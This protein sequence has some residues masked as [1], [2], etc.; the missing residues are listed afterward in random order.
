MSQFYQGPSFPFNPT[1]I[2]GCKLWMD[3][4]DTSSAS[5]TLSGSTVTQWKDKSGNGNNTTAYSGTP[6]ITTNAINS[7]PAISMSGG[8]FTGPFATANTG[9]QL[10]A[11]AVISIDSSSGVWPRPLSLGRPGVVDYADPTT[12][13]AIIRYSGGQAVG[14]GRNSQYQST[15]FP[16][17]SSPFLVQSSHNGPME[18]IGVNGT[19]TPASLNDGQGGNFNITSYG[20]G[21]NTQ[22][23]DYFVWNGYYAE[24]IYFNVQLTLAQQQQVEGYLAW[25][26]GLQTQL[27]PTH[28]YYSVQV[29]YGGS[30]GPAF[31]NL[32]LPQKIYSQ[33]VFVPTQIPGCQIWFDA[34]DPA[35][36]TLSN[37]ST[38]SWLSKGLNNIST[39]NTGVPPT[40]SNYNGY[41]SLFFNSNATMYTNTASNYGTSGTTWITVATNL[42]PITSSSP[43][44]ASVVIATNGAGAER[45]IRFN[46]STSITMYTIN[47]SVI[48]SASGFNANG[49]RGFIDTAAYFSAYQNGSNV[50]SNTTAVTFQSG[51]NQGFVL[52]QWNIGYLYG[53]VNEILIYDTAL[54][55]SN[56]Q[57]IE[58]YLA[59]KWGF[60]NV[61]SNNNP[62]GPTAPPFNNSYVLN[63]RKAIIRYASPLIS[64]GCCLW[65]DANDT[66]SMT[67]ANGNQ[68][69][70]WNDKS[71]N[72]RHMTRQG[73]ASALTL[74]TLN[75]T[76]YVQFDN[77][78][79]NNVYMNTTKFTQ[80][81][82][83][84]I[85]MV[86][87][88]QTT[89][90][91]YSA[92]WS[93]R[94]TAASNY[95]PGL[96]LSNTGTSLQPY[97]TNI[98]A[99]QG[100]STITAGQPY[101]VYMTFSNGSQNLLNLA[102]NGATTY[103][104]G[105][106][107]T[108]NT[109][110]AEFHLGADLYASNY[111]AMNLNELVMFDTILSNDQKQQIE[112]YLAWKWNLG[113]QLPP[114]HACAL[115]P[116]TANK[117]FSNYVINYAG[118]PNT[119]GLNLVSA[120]PSAVNNELQI[121]ANTGSVGSAVWFSTLVNIQS[122][123]TSFVLRFDS[124]NA[125]GACF[126]IQNSGSNV[127]GGGGGSLGYQ[128]I[129]TSVA[130]TF[131]TYNGT[132]GNFSVDY[133]TNGG[134]PPSAGASG[135]LNSSLNLT[136]GQTYNFYVLISYNGT[137][138]SWTIRNL[139]STSLS[140]T[141]NVAINIPTT[142]GSSN[143]AY[144]GFTSGTGGLTETCTI[145][146]WLYNN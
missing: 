37:S 123:T 97:T 21:V 92:F 49:I 94:A 131:K 15:A 62:Y 81:P 133:L 12:T 19:L 114:S 65:L 118:F 80:L 109:F 106:L 115:F 134:T 86:F 66:T 101:L 120:F 143:T 24:V 31:T 145:S 67:I 85:F 10:H 108:F 88:P 26:W 142:V 25:K 2:T 135:L 124:T 132:G 82:L 141:S 48:R 16:N 53:Y 43:P 41:P 40:Y 11:F 112:G 28:P 136:A 23:T 6:T 105:Y 63:S 5:M 39:Y 138:L 107:S 3:A 128:G 29:F 22:T 70:Q 83:M 87:T 8:Y 50:T 33:P 111:G 102:L 55:L 27:P 100:V 77:A 52:G 110:Q 93:W 78:T 75:A 45:A 1:Q 126:V 74:Q 34:S 139:F 99:G 103:T 20:L 57:K 137:T 13:F 130:I 64:Q 58:A 76:R 146:S 38:I 36:L 90:G 89:T 46:A 4:A 54:A 122:F 71:G 98:G 9:S 32:P 116:P 113:T 119:S 73:T 129:G 30:A 84:S 140:Y 47:T 35:T 51:T 60:L 125:D 69:S 104:T 56:Y 95:L 59:W 72:A 121:N 144:V 17:Y 18:Y 61:L 79:A 127:V 14:I 91:T 42:A 96:R 7:L 117:V 44:D 68:I